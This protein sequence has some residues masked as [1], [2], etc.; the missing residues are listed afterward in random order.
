[1]RHAA[2]AVVAV[3]TALVVLTWALPW[4]GGAASRK[5]KPVHGRN[6]A[7]EQLRPG[8]IPRDVKLP[9]EEPRGARVGAAEG[10]S[11]DPDE[12]APATGPG[13]S[14]ALVP[15][16]V[17]ADETIVL[18]AGMDF[19][20]L[21]A[22]GVRPAGSASGA[23]DPRVMVRTS[24]DGVQWAEWTK[25]TLE[26]APGDVSARRLMADPCWVGE[27]RYV[28]FAVD[29]SVED[30][31][32]SFVNSLGEA[33]VADRVS[34]V[35]GAAVAT[36]AGLWRP[37]AADAMTSKPTIVTRSQ[38][39]ADESL[40]GNDPG[41]AP[42]KMAFV[43]HS[44]NGNSYSR[45]EAPALVR[46]I[47]YYHVRGAGFEDLGYNFLID[48]FG[49]V[50]EGRYGGVEK[51]VIGAQTLG[52]NT[53]STGVAL[54]GTYTSASPPSAAVA[55]LKRLLAWKLDVHHVNPASSATM[56]CR[57]SDKYEAGQTVKL[58]AISG[59]RNA[60]YTACPGNA[61][62]GKL[63]AIRSAVAGIGLPKI[64]APGVSLNVFSPDGDGSDDV[65]KLSFSASET[66][67]WSMQIKNTGGTVVRRYSGSA[68][69]ASRIWDGKDG[70]GARLPDG[71]YTVRVTG[72]SSRGNAR[73]A[74]IAILVDTEPP[75]IDGLTLAPVEIGRKADS[76][77]QAMKISYDVSEVVSTRVTIRRADGSR[78]RTPS[79]WTRVGEGSRTI[80]WDGTVEFLGVKIPAPDGRYGVMVEARDR[81][82]TRVVQRA[83]AYCDSDA[84]AWGSGAT[85]CTAATRSFTIL[86]GRE[87]YFRFKVL[88]APAAGEA[89]PS[90]A[91]KVTFKIRDA[92]GRSRHTR[93]LT[94]RLNVTSSH[95]ISRCWLERGLYTY[96]VYATLP[97]GR[98]QQLV[99]S[100]QF[101]IR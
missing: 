29:G 44:V 23:D 11:G 32:I 47:Y 76:R 64:Y 36:V 73:A 55:S 99:K 15:D 92:Q 3:I 98:Q 94:R 53:G 68:R 50:Y 77:R 56:L 48:R 16:S 10:Q 20:L 33:T 1:M 38:W 37:G 27:A 6:V 5:P 21:G 95:T 96:S 43:H 63:P 51:G 88:Y 91:A 24:L 87:A 59:H 40:R 80:T 69:S 60:N 90:A 35:V 41:Y 70:N 49:T 66:L 28:Q 57:A 72:S 101:R 31:E 8:V 89:V 9:P 58:A 62:Y 2:L 26:S 82:G 42:V 79:D 81:A 83:E 97:D 34:D 30:L 22:V 46:A 14:D 25:L 74:D 4:A 67:R 18:D 84:A 71:A 93:E 19:N 65:T 100:A 45:S 54:I 78:A 13:T 61:L 86:R 12:G 17:A 85:F 7:V 39:G 75:R 52:F